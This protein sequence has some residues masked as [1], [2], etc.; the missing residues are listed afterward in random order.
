MTNTSIKTSADGTTTK[1]FNT[2]D[3]VSFI[4]GLK[5]EFVLSNGETITSNI[6][7]NY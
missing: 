4:E 5:V 2:E 3:L 7:V 6:N 1:M